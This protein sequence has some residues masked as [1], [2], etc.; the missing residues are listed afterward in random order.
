MSIIGLHL[1][2]ALKCSQLT[3]VYFLLELTELRDKNF[4][5]P[6]DKNTSHKQNR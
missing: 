4:A 2:E 5:E 6:T 1:N 3:A